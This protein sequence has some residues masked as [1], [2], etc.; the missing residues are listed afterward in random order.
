MGFMGTLAE[1][2]RI[3]RHASCREQDPSG[4]GGAQPCAALGAVLWPVSCRD[5]CVSRLVGVTCAAKGSLVC[6][7]TACA[8]E[9]KGAF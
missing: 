2:P 9:E 1:V 8:S 3:P 6:V 4:W 7:C 5:L